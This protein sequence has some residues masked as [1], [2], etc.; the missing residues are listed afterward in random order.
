MAALNAVRSICAS[1]LGEIDKTIPAG[2]TVLLG[3]TEDPF[4]R[5][6]RFSGLSLLSPNGWFP[7][8]QVCAGLSKRRQPDPGFVGRARGQV[9]TQSPLLRRRRNIP[10]RIDAEHQHPTNSGKSW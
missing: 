1:K 6:T 9:A 3:V 7:R 2:S 8:W 4:S 10:K 5:N